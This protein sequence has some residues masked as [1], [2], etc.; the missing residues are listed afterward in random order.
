MAER[1]ND[2]TMQDFINI[3]NRPLSFIEELGLT[4]KQAEDEGIKAFLKS[5]PAKNC[6]DAATESHDMRE[7]I[8][9]G[10]TL[11]AQDKDGV[12]DQIHDFV[13][14][15]FITSYGALLVKCASYSPKSVSPA[16]LFKIRS[17]QQESARTIADNV[18][19]LMKGSLDQLEAKQKEAEEEEADDETDKEIQ[20]ELGYDDLDQAEND[21]KNHIYAN[22]HKA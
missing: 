21:I 17:L 8:L 12:L 3:E 10:F 18:E 1:Q 20:D 9:D 5:L 22:N 11:N 15:L 14:S 4:E 2:M 7:T 13:M 19:K 6:E 16:L